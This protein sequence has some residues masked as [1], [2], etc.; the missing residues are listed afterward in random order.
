MYRPKNETGRQN[1]FGNHGIYIHMGMR[2][3][4]PP[5]INL[6]LDLRKS[7]TYETYEGMT[8]MYLHKQSLLV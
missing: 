4:I 6:G 2:M 1:N 8:S 7:P 5:I 3:H